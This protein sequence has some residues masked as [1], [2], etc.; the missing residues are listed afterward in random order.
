MKLWDFLARRM[1][2]HASLPAF[3]DGTSYAALLSLVEARAKTCGGSGRLIP[4][5]RH[6]RREQAVEIL[7][8]LASGNAAVPLDLA[9][10]AKRFEA[11]W[12]RIAEGG[13]RCPDLAFV[14]FTSGTSGDPKGVMLT[15]ENIL[16]NLRMIERYFPLEA[17]ERL[18]IARPLVHAAVL[19][20]EL[21]YGLCRGA[22]LSFYEEA[23][24]PSRLRREIEARSVSVLCGTPTLFAH[25]AAVSRGKPCGL[26]R[27]AISGE[28]LF[29]ETAQKIAAAFPGVRF[30]HVYGLTEH[31]PRASA[32]PPV[33]V[34]RR[35]G[36]VGRLL[37]GV[38]GRIADDGELL[39]RSPCV[40]KGY[41]GDPAATA[42]KIEGG[43]L[44]TGDLVRQDAGGYLYILGRKDG[45]LIRCGVNILP[46]EIEEAASACPG[47]RACAVCGEADETKGQKITLFFQGEVLPGKVRAFLAERLATYLMPD[48]VR[49]AEDLP[50]SPGG[51]R[52]RKC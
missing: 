24:Q 47:V 43:W 30:Y 49:R 7:A 36:S 45:M 13:E 11:V 33:E 14:L 10:G 19:T 37:P 8:V 21:L 40:M 51:K 18:L 1:R 34:V 26:K 9:Y 6:L 2:A 29:P 3:A 28:R 20:G 15:D 25:L 46:E 31:A 52:V 32:W 48:A 39:L 22:C 42:A 44:K 35:A 5:A 17:G 38:E 50:V 23:F 16:E 27:C 12:R 41:F 4:V